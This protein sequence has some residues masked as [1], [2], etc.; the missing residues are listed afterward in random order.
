MKILIADDD[1]ICRRL[2]ESKLKLQGHEVASVENGRKAWTLMQRDY[3]PVL[4]LDWMMP[5]LDGLA[6]ARHIRKYQRGNYTYI[7]LLSAREGRT[8][9]LEAMKAGVDDF[10]SKPMDEEQLTARIQVAERILGLR[11][12]VDRLEGLLPICSFCKKIRNEGDRWENVEAY[13]ARHTEAN[14]SR[15]ICQDCSNEFLGPT[16]E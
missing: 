11:R 10:L 7:V 8:H 2:L 1:D 12:H 4:I 6:L 9:Y 15:T 5:V 13:I 3:Y 14:F 16:P